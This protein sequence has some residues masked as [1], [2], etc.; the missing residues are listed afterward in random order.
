LN[1][2]TAIIVLKE[3]ANRVN[4]V[5]SLQTYYSEFSAQKA[6]LEDPCRL[7]AALCT[8]RAGKSSGVGLALFLA[9]LDTPGSSQLYVALTRESAKRI[10]H[11]DVLKSL[12]RRF[13]LGAKFN[14]TTLDV[15]LPNGSQIYLLGLDA[16]T[17]ERDK[18]LGQKYRRAVIDE[19]ASFRQDLS[20]I[21]SKFIRPALT[22]LRGDLLLVG[23][24]GNHKNFFY[25]VTTGKVSGWSVHRWDTSQNPHM[26]EQWAEEIAALRAENPRIEETPSFRQMYLGEW[27][28]DTSKV[29]Y[30]YEPSSNDIE[31]IPT[32][33]S[34]ADWRYVLGIDLGYNDDT[35]IVVGAYTDYDPV[36]YIVYA[37]KRPKLIVSQVAA[38]AKA[39]MAAYSPC[40]AVVDTASRQS[41]EELRQRHSLPLEP[42]EKRGKSEAIA[43]MNSDMLTGRIRVLPRCGQLTTEWSELI[44]D[45]RCAP[46]LVEHPGC[47]NHLCDAALYMWRAARNYAAVDAP[48]LPKLY[49]QEGIDALEDAED[50]QM[51]SDERREWWDR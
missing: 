31:S 21:C 13:K 5:Q 40:I 9:A 20:E 23:T 7:K 24:P 8:R 41:V 11:K 30:R 25:Q 19:C 48:K 28:T 26:A 10:M 32:T 29:V 46:R 2:E 51:A 4:T 6:F 34:A 47:A 43:A 45:E 3:A 49:G 44:W 16:S 12:N 42:A 15:K 14:E 35:A 18:I 36:L 33:Q 50:A 17:H 38:W 37:E 22:D 27:V 1:R 39:I